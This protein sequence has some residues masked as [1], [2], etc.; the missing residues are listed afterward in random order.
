LV[1]KV[2]PAT[3]P[4]GN[5]FNKLVENVAIVGIDDVGCAVGLKRLKG[6]RHRLICGCPIHVAG[7]VHIVL[8]Q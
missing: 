3:P 2:I 5:G 8:G 7:P 1:L 6:G 4:V